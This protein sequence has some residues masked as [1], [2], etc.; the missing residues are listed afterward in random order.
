MTPSTTISIL[1]VAAL[2]TV[3]VLQPI[4]A[5]A[6]DQDGGPIASAET[7]TANISPGADTD[8]FTFDGEIGQGIVIEMADIADPSGLFSP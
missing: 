2:L 7:K 1:A 5:W 4:T 3:N 8:E 6:Q